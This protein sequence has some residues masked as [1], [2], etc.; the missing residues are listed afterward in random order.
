MAGECRGRG[1]QWEGSAAVML[2]RPWGGGREECNGADNEQRS[3]PTCCKQRPI[4]LLV[5]AA[6][7]GGGWLARGSAAGSS[8]RWEAGLQA[9]AAA[10]GSQQ[11]P[12]LRECPP[13][14]VLCLC[15]NPTCACVCIVHPTRLCVS[16][17]C[18]PPASAT[19]AARQLQGPWRSWQSPAAGQPPGARW[20]PCGPAESAASWSWRPAC[21][22]QGGGQLNGVRR[23]TKPSWRI[24]PSA[25]SHAPA[26]P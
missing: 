21:G 22:G 20:R 2:G 5:A 6:A 24:A 12:C 1:V 9:A 14:R 15:M 4:L 17:S 10:E 8:S 19:A 18:T 23:R 3:A 16:A 25:L 7:A 13:P 11:P 26:T